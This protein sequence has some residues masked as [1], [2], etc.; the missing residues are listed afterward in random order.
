MPEKV[1]NMLDCLSCGFTYKK[2]TPFKTP[3]RACPACGMPTPGTGGK[4]LSTEGASRF[5]PK[6]P[7]GMVPKTDSDE[8]EAQKAGTS[9]TVET[10]AAATGAGGIS[11][12][13]PT[14]PPRAGPYT[15]PA[16]E[17]GAFEIP[18]C[19][20]DPEVFQKGEFCP[21]CHVFEKCFPRVLILTL[22]RLAG[23]GGGLG[24]GT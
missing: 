14:P 22:N 17:P 7:T 3:V 20:G 10:A 15:S 16:A 13:M 4:K 23:S 24:R 9:T 8:A 18:V 11:P 5:I 12:P 19:F 1:A 21:N 2:F 6:I